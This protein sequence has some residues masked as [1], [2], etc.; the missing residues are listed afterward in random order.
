MGMGPFRPSPS[1]FE[2]DRKGSLP[3]GPVKKYDEPDEDELDEP[4]WPNPRADNYKITGHWQTGNYLIVQI[5]YLDCT[6]YEGEKI[7]VFDNITLEDLEEQELIDPHF[8]DNSDYYSPIARFI[9]TMAGVIMA[10]R[11]CKMMAGQ[12]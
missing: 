12:K 4:K 1:S 5:K 3:H 6:N 7:L 2:N 10:T 9:P 8:C 11:F